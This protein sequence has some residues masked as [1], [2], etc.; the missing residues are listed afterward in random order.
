MKMKAYILGIALVL[1]AAAVSANP[2][3]S[4]GRRMVDGRNHVVHKIERGETLYGL[5][6]KYSVS[7][8]EIKKANPGIESAFNVGREVL[9]PRK[10]N[11][12]TAANPVKP[13]PVTP[14]PVNPTPP[15]E[16]PM[17]GS[18]ATKNTVHTVASGETLSAIARKYGV[19]VQ[20]IKE[21]NNL[22]TDGV[23]VGQRLTIKVKSNGVQPIPPV[24][25]EPIQ[26][27]G[28][29]NGSGNSGSGQGNQPRASIKPAENTDPGIPAESNGRNRDADQ[30]T[31]VNEDVK[32]SV[33]VREGID[34]TRNYLLHPAARVGTIVMLSN[35]ATNVRV[36][37]RVVGNYRSSEMPGIGVQV[38]Q[39]V[40]DALA[41][42]SNEFNLRLNY[43][44]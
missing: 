11:G 13:T 31:E 38:T 9:I 27:T 18:P 7:A 5:C 25:T 26:V 14:A 16:Q 34:Q 32:A 20:Q 30:G 4:I 37:A 3:D 8:E 23:N 29:G 40:R 42:G 24:S 36:F 41:S 33:I 1:T 10:W 39:A 17:A 22:R 35:P 44:R 19:T 12:G 6:R 2:A 21:D 15:V 43:A 28:E